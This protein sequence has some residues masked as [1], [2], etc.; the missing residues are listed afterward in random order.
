MG[1]FAVCSAP[2]EDVRYRSGESSV[3]PLI[4]ALVYFPVQGDVQDVASPP[5]SFSAMMP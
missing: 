5:K 4:L 2:V 1:N 3:P